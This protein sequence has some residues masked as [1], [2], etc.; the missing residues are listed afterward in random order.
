[1][2]LRTSEKSIQTGQY[3]E[4]VTCIGIDSNI[5][6]SRKRTKQNDLQ[7]IYF[8]VFCL[9]QSQNLFMYFLHVI[10]SEEASLDL[11]FASFIITH[12]KF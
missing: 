10:N 1:M 4:I 5:C 8:E 6:C 9:V 3:Y 11:Y 2:E 7:E 12:V